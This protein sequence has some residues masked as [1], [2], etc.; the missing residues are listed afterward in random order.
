MKICYPNDVFILRGNH[1]VRGVCLK[2]G[3]KNEVKK[4]YP[5]GEIFEDF[6]ETFKFTPFAALIDSHILCIHGGIGPLVKSIKSIASIVRPVGKIKKKQAPY[7]VLWSD[8]SDS[9]EEYEKS[10]RGYGHLFGYNHCIEFEKNNGL[11]LI[12]RGHEV[13]ING[14]NYGFSGRVLTVFS[15]SNY[16][17]MGNDG[18][19]VE[20]FP[21]SRIRGHTHRAYPT[22]LRAQDVVFYNACDPTEKKLLFIFPDGTNSLSVSRIRK[23]K[24]KRFSKGK[25]RSKSVND[26]ASDDIVLPKSNSVSDEILFGCLILDDNFPD[27]AVAMPRRRAKK[28]PLPPKPLKIPTMN[29][30]LSSE[31]S[32]SECISEMPSPSVID[33]ID[34]FTH[35]MEETPWSSERRSA[36]TMRKISI[37]NSEKRAKSPNPLPPQD[38]VSTFIE[39]SNG[40]KKKKRRF[41]K[42]KK[43]KPIPSPDM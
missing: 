33:G 34:S 30:H 36:S 7:D 42:C 9:T 43:A 24:K 10:P 14:V 21:G 15:A 32:E 26:D 17:G 5:D 13:A 6:C 16:C 40:E 28:P 18:G 20:V 31:D 11:S 8:P 29:Q 35:K 12:I 38:T 4:K 19:V 27:S 41:K 22:I 37:K 39:I 3:F 2:F 1:E 23:A 25:K